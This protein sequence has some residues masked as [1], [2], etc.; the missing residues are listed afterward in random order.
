MSAR[1]GAGGLALAFPL[2]RAVAI[3]ALG[4]AA[5]GCSSRPHVD[6]RLLA[7]LG[8]AQGYQHQADELEELGDRGGALAR[9]RRVLEIPFPRNA[10]EREDVR[11]DAYGRIAE[12]HLA[13]GDDRAAEQ[14]VARG[15]SERTRTSYFE[16]RLYAVRGKIHQTRARR[17]RVS[18]NAEAARTESHLALDAFER[19][20]RINEQVLGLRRS[21]ARKDGG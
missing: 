12:L 9:V 10:P 1:A 8:L 13:S 11:L 2:A 3:I 7:S 20:I 4:V 15:L 14:S 18:G 21:G 5:Q 17:L 19:S 6:E 16:A